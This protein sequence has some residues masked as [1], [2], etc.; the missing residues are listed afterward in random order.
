M[1][2]DILQIPAIDLDGLK[3]IAVTEGPLKGFTVQAP[4]GIDPATKLNAAI[5]PAKDFPLSI[6]GNVALTAKIRI[7]LPDALLTGL[8]L[9]HPETIA[10]YALLKDGRIVQVPAE[11]VAVDAPRLFV[12]V[13]EFSSLVV[14][15]G[16]APITV[17][18][19][20]GRTVENPTKI[21][22]TPA[23]VGKQP[24]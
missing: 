24:T 12:L 17:V 21:E 10:V 1:A 5:E 13:G 18:S 19:G 20:S 9:T 2:T 3:T 23:P 6:Q 11:E 4:Q 16:K 7:G 14:V 22:W 8:D 15:Q